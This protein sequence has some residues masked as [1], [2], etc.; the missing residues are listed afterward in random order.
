MNRSI[1]VFLCLLLG[2]FLSACSLS[3]LLPQD[4]PSTSSDQA[5]VTFYVEVPHSTPADQGISL[6]VVDETTGLPFHEEVHSMQQTT[7][8]RP[9]FWRF[10]TTL[11][12][13]QNSVIK[14][15]YLREASYP[16][17]EHTLPNQ[18]VRYRMISPI[19]PGEVHDIV[20]K[21]NDTPYE[22][23][24]TGQLSG[25]VTDQVS[26][27][28][29]PGMLVTAG[30]KQTFSNAD[31][32]FMLSGLPPG[33]HHVFVYAPDGTYQFFQQGAEI[34]SQANTYM[35]IQL[36][37]REMVDITFVVQVPPNTPGDQLRLIGNLHQ[38]GNT[39]HDLAGGTSTLADHAPK[40]YPLGE[41][42]YGLILALPAGA[43]LR[44]KYT[45][46]DGF[47]NAEHQ[48]D[49]DFEVRRLVVPDQNQEIYDTVAAWNVGE[50]APVTFS[51]QVPEHTPENEEISLQMNAYGWGSPL[52]MT[53]DQDNPQRWTYTLYS[54]LEAFPEFSYRYCRQDACDVAVPAEARGEDFTGWNVYPASEELHIQDQVE[55]WTWLEPTPIQLAAPPAPL[56][57]QEPGLQLGLEIL[58][59]K[60]PLFLTQ[61]R[62]A[63]TDLTSLAPALIT[64]SPTWSFTQ[65]APP[66]LQVDPTQDLTWYDLDTLLTHIPA[67][68]ETSL[69][70]FPRLRIPKPAAEWW[71]SAPRDYAWWTQWFDAYQTF[72]LHHASLAEIYEVETLV[73]GGENIL[74]ALPNGKLA[75]GTSSGVPVDIDQRWTALIRAV[76]AQYSGNIAWAMPL[77]SLT[78][79][80]YAFLNEVDQL[81]LIWSPPLAESPGASLES[82]Q[83]TAQEALDLELFPFYQLWVQP[84]QLPLYLVSGYPSARG[85]ST[86][87]IEIAGETC[88]PPESLTDPA[89]AP[90]AVPV[91]YQEQ[92]LS[93]LALLNILP[94]QKWVAGYIVR[95]YAFPTTLHDPTLSI[96]GKPA[97]DLLFAGKPGSTE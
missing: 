96:R 63:Q 37:A 51:V 43:E 59:L 21:W 10:T 69:V 67:D 76:K 57:P 62:N 39:F 56:D 93:H 60:S 30:G 9:G 89:S 72:L 12:V 36:K 94:E 66:R 91:S 34:A 64:L 19:G 13:P 2:F 55:Q 47:W 6:S 1:K 41:N 92:A 16:I 18:P 68:Q 28:P 79:S 82:M 32:R 15:R 25:E 24:E 87:C 85:G 17:L 52:P 20:T 53:Q 7:G 61:L 22:G 42:Q 49:G 44:Y 5:Q 58:S 70:L 65:T 81:H 84:H 45:L 40:L 50:L 95:G 88:L 11:S 74:P 71:T 83:K 8:A 35:P 26:G 31:G 90:T 75:D 23:P 54:P 33:I 14:Y 38:V 3:S 27:E 46:G 73:L 86:S 78:E 48:E 80:P 97:A 29:L 4:Q 77:P